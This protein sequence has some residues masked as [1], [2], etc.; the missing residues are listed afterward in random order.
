MLCIRTFKSLHHFIL[1]HFDSS[2]PQ[3]RMGECI[4][5][6]SC[7]RLTLD[8]RPTRATLSSGL[9]IIEVM[10]VSKKHHEHIYTQR[11]LEPILLKVNSTL[12]TTYILCHKRCVRN[13]SRKITAFLTEFGA[14]YSFSI[15]WELQFMLSFRASPT[16]RNAIMVH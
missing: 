10:F 16:L 7:G 15:D 14:S 1:P 3:R 4:N 12:Y 13:C 5:E 8:S 9:A 6:T 2:R 11:N